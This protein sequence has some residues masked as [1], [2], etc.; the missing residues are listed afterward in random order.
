MTDLLIKK[1]A[2]NGGKVSSKWAKIIP[3]IHLNL[4]AINSWIR[5]KI[6]LL[7]KSRMPL[8]WASIGLSTANPWT[9]KGM[10]AP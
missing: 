2:K 5:S 3:K 9:Y 10:Y 4:L 7:E 6:T 1:Y 8:F